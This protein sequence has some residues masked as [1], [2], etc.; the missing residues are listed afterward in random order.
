MIWPPSKPISM[1]TRSSAIADDLREHAVYGVGM[2][3]RDLAPEEPAPGRLVDQL[4]ALGGELVD[5][6]THVV[7]L[8][9]DVVHAGT[10][11][12]E[13]LADGRV[14]AER[15]EQLGPAGADSQRGRFDAL[16]R[17]RLAV[18]EPRAEET[19]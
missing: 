4:G 6:D 16:V 10:A 18:L 15:R 3:E 19:L 17:H 13:E 1:R 14:V 9:G 11:L 2:C 12:G 8:V 7:D 5:R